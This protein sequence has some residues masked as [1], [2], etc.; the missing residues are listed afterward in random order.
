MKLPMMIQTLL[1]SG[2]SQDSLAK[3][4]TERGVACTQPTIWRIL[5]AGA[6]PRYTLGDAIRQLYE[7]TTAENNAA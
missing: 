4:L 6:E 1:E 5:N 2:Y 3:K 7:E